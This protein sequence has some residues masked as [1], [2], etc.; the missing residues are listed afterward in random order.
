VL[1]ELAAQ[2]GVDKSGEDGK[3]VWFRVDDADLRS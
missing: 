1:D 3:V 2:W